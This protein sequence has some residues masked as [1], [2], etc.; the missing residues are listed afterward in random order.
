MLRRNVFRG[1]VSSSAA[2]MR[3]LTI[4]PVFM[5][6][7]SP[8]MEQGKVTEW[9]LKVGDKISG[10]ET[11]CKIETDKA[12]VGFDNVADE[13]FIAKLLVDAPSDSVKVGS[14]VLLLVDEEAG[15]NSPD[16]ANWKPDAP[17]PASSAAAAPAAPAAPAASAPVAAAAAPVP[18]SGAR[19]FASPLAKVTA[20]KLGVSLSTVVGTGG[21]VGRVTKSDV[22]AAAKAGPTTAAVAAPA[23]VAAAST[24]VAVAAPKAAPKAAAPA[25]VG[26]DYEDTPV[27][28]MR[29][30]I[31]KRL[32]Q[33]KNIE[34]PHYYLF[35]ECKADN[36]LSVIKQLNA[37]GDGS[38]KIS[39]N[40]YIVKAVARANLIVPAC[41]SSWQGDFIRQYKG[42]D[43]SVAVA[44]PTGLIT[45]II[46]NAHA[47]GLAEIS[48]E[49][50]AL[51]KKARE[52]TLQPAEFIGGTVSVSNLGAS[53][54]PSFTA[55]INPPQA[56]ILAVGTLV[57]KPEISK[58]EEGEF[59]LSGKVEQTISFTA[60]FDH[61]VVDGAI[62]A[63]WFKHFKDAIENPLSL[64]L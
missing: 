33:S 11:Y 10:G 46:K 61:R 3:C 24:P 50:K 9:S 12:V 5:P 25:V 44:T 8:T 55:I 17:A 21:A 48:Q 41:N 6:S 22:E 2:S 13:G 20:A 15:V 62:G 34:V 56:M 47:K 19:V 42:V 4:T 31:A 32:T 57:P 7:L 27:T 45:P 58:N 63:E 26:G 54:I 35:N 36:M 43:V 49:T 53:G 60:S 51:A 38:F 59:V 39:V 37:K 23:S 14:P 52:G 40:D 1:L 30:T 16:V 18:V 28:S 29:A 64:L